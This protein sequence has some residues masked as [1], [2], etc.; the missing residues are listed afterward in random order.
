MVGKKKDPNIL[1]KFDSGSFADSAGSAGDDGNT[2]SIND[3]MQFICDRH[4]VDGVCCCGSI[5]WA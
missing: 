1:G 4:W 5:A 3:W 2:A